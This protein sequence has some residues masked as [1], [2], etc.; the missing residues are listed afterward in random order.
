MAAGNTVLVIEHNLDVIKT[1]DWIIDLGPEGGD[2]GGE[3]VVAGLAGGGRGTTRGRTRARSW[4]RCSGSAGAP[5]RRAGRAPGA[6]FASQ[7]ANG[8]RA[9]LE[10][11]PPCSGVIRSKHRSKLAARAAGGGGHR[12]RPARRPATRPF[13]RSQQGSPFV[14]QVAAGDPTTRAACRLVAL[15][16]GREPVRV[17]SS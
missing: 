7:V 6:R 12:R 15:G 14:V 1:A 8:A 13:R 2:A 4:P 9:L 3:V 16:R 5:E 11:A 17:V 10:L